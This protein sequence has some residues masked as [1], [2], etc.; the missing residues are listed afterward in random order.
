MD[1]TKDTYNMIH[2]KNVKAYISM[3]DILFSLFEMFY[4]LNFLIS[5]QIP[6]LVMETVFMVQAAVATSL[7]TC[8]TL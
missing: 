7:P 3:S 2:L 4:V 5:A 8:G 6:S 1:V